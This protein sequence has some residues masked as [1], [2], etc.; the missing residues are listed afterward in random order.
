LT[1]IA[2]SGTEV[3]VWKRGRFK[4]SIGGG[5]KRRGLSTDN[6]LAIKKKPW[7]TS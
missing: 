5:V 6:S 3:I 4:K 1:A 7:M 2:I